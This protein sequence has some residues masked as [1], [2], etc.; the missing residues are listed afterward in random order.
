MPPMAW[1][2]VCLP[3]GFLT[4]GIFLIFCGKNGNQIHRKKKDNLITQIF[5]DKK[6]WQRAPCKHGFDRT[7]SLKLL[8]LNQANIAII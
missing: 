2:S 5:I 7:E 6:M 1:I 4:Y 3:G 8:F